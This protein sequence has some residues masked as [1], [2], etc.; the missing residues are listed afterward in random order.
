VLERTS[1]KIFAVI[2]AMGLLTAAFLFGFGLGRSSPSPANSGLTILDE[3]RRHIEESSVKSAESK[4]LIQSAMRGMLASL[5]DQYAEY[6]D[7]QTYESFRD[8]SAG[9][10]SGVGLWL[11]KDGDRIKVVTVLAGTPA[12]TAGMKNGDVI[13]ALNGKPASGSSLE[14]VVQ[15]I[16]GKP[17]TNVKISVLR[18]GQAMDFT[19]IR[20]D[21]AVP[22][23]N[24][25][26]LKDKLGV[27]EIVTFSGGAGSQ[28]RDSVRSLT[29]KGARGFI[30]D[31]RGN[32]GG[33]VDE[34]VN[35]ASSFL[36]GGRV[37]S[38]KERGKAEVVYDAR[39]SVET[40]LPLVVLVDEGSA[41]ASEIV[42]GAVQDRHRG[43]I[44]GV[45]TY[46]KGSVQTVF[47][48]SD[49]SAIKLTTASY[50]TP[51]GRSIGE[52]GVI[53]DVV[54]ADKNRQLAQAQDAL[55]GILAG[56]I[57]GGSQPLA[58]T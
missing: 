40:N 11:K 53:P 13:T 48:L 24:S 7:P 18:D 8:V 12:A 14:Q 2:A 56:S 58:V 20:R 45:E 29:K 57:S 41:S 9:H 46:G 6:L 15:R 36:D 51:S 54:E 37:V 10:F 5:G 28:V 33:L 55:H 38:Y 49:G 47:P 26:L 42:A 43:L 50:Y 30:L 32:P 31:L 27:I 23:V 22:S 25:R 19:L 17:G 4:E 21:I 44:V 34:A 16:K 1:A 35:V 39:G 3:A 52:H